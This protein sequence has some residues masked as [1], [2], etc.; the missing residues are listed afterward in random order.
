MHYPRI[1]KDCGYLYKKLERLLSGI[2]FESFQLTFASTVRTDLI[3]TFHP[4][5]RWDALESAD[6]IQAA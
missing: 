3:H 1:T 6:D 2:T 4:Q 5:D